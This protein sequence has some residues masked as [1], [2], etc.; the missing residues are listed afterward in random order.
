MFGFGYDGDDGK[1]VSALRDM[2]DGGGSGQSGPRF[3]GGGIVSSAANTVFR[4][5][6]SRDRG[7]PDMRTGP[8]GFAR[9]M[10]DG[11]GFNTSG[12]RFEGGNMYGRLAGGLMNRAGIRPLGYSERQREALPGVLEA[13]MAGITPPQANTAG[14]HAPP[15]G[16]QPQPNVTTTQLPDDFAS[17]LARLQSGGINKQ[18][19]GRGAVGMPVQAM[20]Y[21]GRG[22]VGMPVQ[23]QVGRPYPESLRGI[24]TMEQHMRA[25]SPFGGS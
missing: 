5:S 23:G 11:G 13:I 15:L 17:M 16:L 3:E 21:G 12:N 19:G 4:P 18:Y 10:V 14:Q 9:D 6:G 7:E 25:A 22:A 2:F 24:G 20:Q 8:M 1:S